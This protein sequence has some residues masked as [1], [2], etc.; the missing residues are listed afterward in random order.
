VNDRGDSLLTVSDL[1]VVFAGRA[2]QT[3]AVRGID[4][5][6]S[7]GQVLG[8]AGESGSGKTASALAIMGL[9]PTGARVSGSIT[10][11]NQEL[12]GLPE[13]DLRHLR[14]RDIA[15]VFQETASALNPVIR[16]GDQI[17]MAIRA[18]GH[19][20]KQDVR[21]RIES[22]LRTVQL[23]D[24][25][26]VLESYPHQLSGGM[27]QRVMIAMALSCGSKV[28][29][30]DEPTTALDVS[31]QAEILEVVRA[32]ATEE[33]L[34]VMLISHDLAVLAKVCDQLL[35]MYQGEVVERGPAD[36]LLDAPA[37]PY[38]QAL[39]ACLPS[40]HGPKVELPDL[41]QGPAQPADSGGC[42]FAYRC[43]LRAAPCVH[44]PELDPL[45]GGDP[46][47]SVRCWR[48][49]DA[50]AIGLGAVGDAP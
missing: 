36:Q 46:A 5:S 2:Q 14:G 35:V 21:E 10:Y 22:A 4:F 27:C 48:A 11:R 49:E 1:G 12:V 50:L 32:L 33:G 47:R 26:R 20:A 38:T 31:V 39:I 13:K 8:V 43:P 40:L 23:G 45:P 19:R 6:L 18:H 28:L 17:A 9:L 24:T 42:R 29:L 7:P 3:Q 30:A 34:A 37:H 16:I 44:H 41:T 15:M 25:E